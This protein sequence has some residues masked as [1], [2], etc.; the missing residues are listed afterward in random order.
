M[1]YF[2]YLIIVV[3]VAAFG[4]GLYFAGS[5]QRAR[6]Q[7]FDDRRINDLQSLQYQIFYH[8][9]TKGKLPATIAELPL[10]ETPR[11]PETKQPYEYAFLGPDTYKVCAVFSLATPGAGG[12]SGES[13]ARVSPYYG[14]EPYYVGT[15]S[16]D[17]PAGYYCFT[18][19]ID[20][21]QYKKD[22]PT[23]VVR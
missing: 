4:L 10:A 6:Q 12:T 21:A 22:H 20:V 5:P 19:T 16:W 23:S 17:H 2:Q 11:D 13:F 9:E 3:V 1:K 18:R 14:K 8:W 7:R 15:Y